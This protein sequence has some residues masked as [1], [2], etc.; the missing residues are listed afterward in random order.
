MEPYQ[1]Q[2]IRFRDWAGYAQD[3]F[4]VTPRLTLMYGLRYEYNGPAYTRNDN[5]Y[6]FDL[7]TGK[8]VIPGDAAR[9]YVSAPLSVFGRFRS[10]P[11]QM[12]V[13][14]SLPQGDYTTSRRAS[15]AYRLTRTGRRPSAGGWGLYY[16]PHVFGR[17]PSHYVAG[18]FSV[19]HGEHHSFVNG[20]PQFT[21]GESVR[22]SRL[23]GDL[24]A[25][26]HCAQ[27]AQQLRAAIQPLHRA[28]VARNI[29]LRVSY[30]GRRGRSLPTGATPTSPWHRRCP[31]RARGARTRSSPTSRTPTTGPTCS[32]A[33]SDAGSK[34]SAGLD[35]HLGRGPGPKRS[36]TSTIAAISS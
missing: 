17:H 31:S 26:R 1:P 25:G 13:G 2:Y 32:T 3:D 30:I 10:R 20:Q 16:A 15:I 27:P 7:A 9:K 36:A 5:I 33:A 11:D 34:R 22:H 4:R 23:A 19:N 14:R 6:S 29:G 24:G 8:I 18:P 28:Q 35:V 21:A 12:G